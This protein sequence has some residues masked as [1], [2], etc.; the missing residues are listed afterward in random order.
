MIRSMTGYG[1]SEV[2]TGWGLLSVEIRS[3]NNRY[4]DIQVRTPKGLAA[5]EPRLRKAVQERF[6]RGRFELFITR[7]GS[8]DKASRLIL[9]EDM[10]SQYIGIL[11]EL[12]TRFSLSGDVDLPLVAGIP[13]LITIAETKEDLESLWPSLS[14][15]LSAAVNDLN[16]MREQEG[17]AL[18]A[19]VRARLDTIDGLIRSIQERAPVT[20]TNAK[21][22]LEDA[23]RR[24]MSEKP[25]PLRLEQEIAIIAERTDVTEELT[26]L[27]SHMNQFR[28]MLSGS[29]NSD[30][31]GRKLDFM[32]QE[33]G[34][35]ANTIAS[36][37]L[38]AEISLHV[39]NI[40]AEL[41]KIREQVQN[42]E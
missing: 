13:N 35:E 31:V 22:R 10:A 4:M 8:E 11:R 37:S 6:S 3:V 28:G 33:M 25:D 16:R 21:K 32:L 19:D 34:R 9:D 15:G 42:I 39:V 30:A 41:E 26:R 29:G 27:D 14:E 2:R 40:K 7:N 20:V 36:K 12:K 17:E 5:L 23:L 24:L 18:S 38:D 1:R